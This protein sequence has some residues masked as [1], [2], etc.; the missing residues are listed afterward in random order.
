MHSQAAPSLSK[1]VTI[2]D[3][4]DIASIPIAPDP[5]KQSKT[6]SVKINIETVLQNVE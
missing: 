2:E 4:L 1:K 3:P 5:E 6:K